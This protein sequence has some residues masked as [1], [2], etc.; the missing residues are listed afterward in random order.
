MGA[1]LALVV[2]AGPGIGQAVGRRF[3]REGFRVVLASRRPKR[4]A[5]IAATLAKEDIDAIPLS[6]DVSDLAALHDA[7]KGVALEYGDPEVLVYNAAHGPAV[8]PTNIEPDALVD[9]LCVNVVGALVSAQVVVEHMRGHSR[10]TVLFTGEGHALSPHPEAAVLGMGKA[11]LR[12]LTFSLAQEL[13]PH[14]IHV[15]TV[16][17]TGTIAPRTPF[18]PKFVAEAFWDLHC[19]PA[20]EWSTELVF[21]GRVH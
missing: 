3:G 1:R 6:V 5:R 14:G 15:A 10:G 12:N 7:L 16:T 18:D 9:S 8:K 11:A 20:G 13:E 4:V 17:V 2:G 19:E 21:H